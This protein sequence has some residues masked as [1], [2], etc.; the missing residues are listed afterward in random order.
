MMVKPDDPDG[1][2]MVT[3]G[4][5]CG[6]ARNRAEARSWSSATLISGT[7]MLSTKSV[8]AKAN[9]PLLNDSTRALFI[10]VEGLSISF[11]ISTASESTFL[12]SSH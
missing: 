11:A 12:V 3:Y 5:S 2:E 1:R 10:P 6:I 7:V 4:T 9:T 8:I